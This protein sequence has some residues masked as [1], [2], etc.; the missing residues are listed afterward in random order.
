MRSEVA[1]RALGWEL[2]PADVLRLVR[3]DEHPVALLGSWA[4]GC[5]IVASDPV[6][7][8]AAPDPVGEV[9]DTPLSGPDY[10]SERAG[11]TPFGGGWIGYLGFAASRGFLPTPP[12]PGGA[13]RLPAWWFG[14]YDHVLRRD[15]ATGTW[16]FEALWTPGR[17]DALEHR[18]RELSCRANAA[19]PESPGYGCGSFRLVPSAEEHKAAVRQTV[20]YI[21][22]GDI[23][24]ANICLRLEA[25]FAGDP[26]DAF[27]LAVTRL[28]PPYAAFLQTGDG[29]V[30]SLSPELFLRRVGTDVLSKPIKGTRSRPA[31]EQDA[32]HEREVLESSAKD[33]AENV[34]IVD[35]MRNDLSRVCVPGS[36][37][38]PALMR[39][40]PHPGVW[41]LVSDVRGTLQPEA[42]DG[43]LIAAAF[44]PGSVT[45]APKVRALEIISELEATP[46]EV[47]TGAIGFRSPVAGL[48][49]NVAI[50]TFEFHGEKVWLG[51]G[52]GITADSDPDNEY[53]E[54]LLKAGPLIR[55]LDARLSEAQ[56]VSAISRSLR[57]RPASGVFTSLRVTDGEVHDLPEHLARLDASTFQLFGKHLPPSLLSD[58]AVRLARLPSGRL[59][60]A[61][62]PFGG[63]LQACVEVIPVGPV[64]SA[65]TL[66]PVTIPGG[67]GDHKWLDRRL[68]A[69]LREDGETGPGEHLLIQD[70]NGEVLETDRANVFAVIDG[71][72][73]TPPADGRLLP[74]VTRAALLRLAEEVGI[75]VKVAPLSTRRLP[76]ASEVFVANS[77][78]GI[79]PARSLDGTTAAW[80]AGPVTRRLRAAL[81]RRPAARGPVPA[82]R[83]RLRPPRPAPRSHACPEIIL[84]DNYDSF[85][86]NLAHLIL[87]NGCRIEVVRNDE[88]T[89]Q[90]VAACGAAGIVISPGPG[91]P[92]DAAISVD[93]V[94]LCGPV[95]PLLGICLGHQ[96]IGVA[97]GARVIAAPRPV[98]GRSSQVTHDGRGLLTGL[99]QR[100]PAARY[101]S[102]IVEERSL[103]PDLYVT[104]RSR[105]GLLMGLRHASYGTEGLQ[106]HP[107][108]VLTSHGDTII[109]NFA[110]ALRRAANAR[111]PVGAA[112]PGHAGQ[113]GRQVTLAPVR[114]RSCA[115]RPGQRAPG[116]RQARRRAAPAPPAASASVL[117]KLA[118][119]AR[120]LTS[121]LRL[122][123]IVTPGTLLAWH[124]RLVQ[125]KWAYPNAPGRPPVPGEVRALVEQLARQNPRWGYRRIQGELTGLGYR[126]GEGTIRRI[127]AAAGPECLDRIPDAA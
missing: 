50:R 71:V 24:Q 100:F 120:A 63:P 81:A 78:Y 20:S 18:F 89:A 33:R 11:H 118:R 31:D 10:L 112:S 51:S 14:F 99:P 35:L 65:L 46:R 69:R 61:A 5:D 110:R 122:R 42:A 6:W 114:G 87:G 59:R 9:L 70:A 29:S 88:V 44:P 126:V 125:R 49:L 22:R 92:A 19:R 113:S 3:A 4:G 30:A 68:V 16:S 102:L 54:C 83:P 21:R 107:E 53:R 8:C 67:L 23:F 97:Y 45:G 37:R 106:F 115:A 124:R 90:Q 101:H 75:A 28:D 108:S 34:M 27:C 72:L 105:G 93:V 47:Y 117:W 86:Y 121:Y 62:R 98:H 57:P 96:A 73:H 26:L 64:P 7:V 82:A 41:H 91:T 79:L 74:G 55:A 38:V 109:S 58:L 66:R 36:V 94:R 127:L 95:T 119:A 48:E 52:G 17:A 80:S 2:S 39:A 85:T 13:Y 103:P 111:L 1:Y 77:V 15:R 123:R 104:A 25:D 116:I 40:E 32:Q 12:P 60:V 43:Q 84:I 76:Q 56:A